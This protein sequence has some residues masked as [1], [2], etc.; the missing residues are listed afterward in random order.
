MRCKSDA[1]VNINASP[2]KADAQP[3]I[4]EVCNSVSHIG[5]QN[6]HKLAFRI[7]WMKRNSLGIYLL[8]DS[9]SQGSWEGSDG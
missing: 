7:K 8:L 3:L 9:S 2:C 5:V 4:S 1:Q 6:I